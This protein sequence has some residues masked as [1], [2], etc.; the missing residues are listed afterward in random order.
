M[1]WLILSPILTVGLYTLYTAYRFV[2][3]NGKGFVDQTA[4]FLSYFFIMW[5]IST[6]SEEVAEKIPFVGMD[7]SEMVGWRKDDGEIT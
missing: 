2:Y 4:G 6:R 3:K 1:Q 5:F 7:L